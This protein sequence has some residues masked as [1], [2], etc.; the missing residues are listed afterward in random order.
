MQQRQIRMPAGRVRP[1]AAV[2]LGLGGLLAVMGVLS[3]CDSEAATP[4]ASGASPSVA[5]ASPSPSASSPS[6]S[7][8]PSVAIPAAARVKS[9]KG[10]EAFVRYFFDQVNVAWTTPDPR[11]IESN[12]EEGCKSCASL[13]TTAAELKSKGHKYASRPVTVADTKLVPGAPAG[14]K[15]FETDLQQHRVDVVDP[16]GRVV[17]T[18][19][20]SDAAEDGRSDLEGRSVAH[21]RRC[22]VVVASLCLIAAVAELGCP[23]DVGGGTT[24]GGSRI[25]LE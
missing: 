13:A 7:A 23:L 20:K 11:A 4:D 24:Q 15:Y 5:S 17:L 16:S 14:Q 18:D 10:A 25:M 8:S 1:R 2:A 19:E 9:D 22:L 21:L 12:S 3:G 6:P